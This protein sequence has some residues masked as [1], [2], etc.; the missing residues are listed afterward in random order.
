[1]SIVG[2]TV[3]VSTDVTIPPYTSEDYGKVLSPTEDGV[4]WVNKGTGIQASIV[5]KTLYL[6]GQS[7]IIVDDKTLIFL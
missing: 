7:N 6:S 4:K 3:G 1:M 5:D 2:T